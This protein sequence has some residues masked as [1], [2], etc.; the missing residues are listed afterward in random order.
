[1]A[2]VVIPEIKHEY[3]RQVDTETTKN[4]WFDECIADNKEAAW[5][6]IGT[7]E[8]DSQYQPS[9][10]KEPDYYMQYCSSDDYDYLK[11][12]RLIWGYGIGIIEQDVICS[13]STGKH[14]AEGKDACDTYATE[15]AAG[16]NTDWKRGIWI[17]FSGNRNVSPTRI[18]E[19]VLP[20]RIISLKDL[21]A[22][23]TLTYYTEIEGFNTENIFNI[24]GAFANKYIDATNSKTFDFS[25]ILS[26]KNT[27]QYVR[28]NNNTC[29]NFTN[30]N[31]ID[32]QHT[33]EYSTI[34][35]TPNG[36]ENVGGKYCYANSGITG[37]LK[38]INAKLYQ[39]QYKECNITNVDESNTF[40]AQQ[41]VDYAFSDNNLTNF[42]PNIN[43]SLTTSAVY[44][45]NNTSAN[46]ICSIDFN[47]QTQNIK[48]DNFIINKNY[49]LTLN[50]IAN[51]NTSLY[52]SEPAF[53]VK[54]HDVI[55][56][57]N[58]LKYSSNSNSGYLFYSIGGYIKII[59]SINTTKFLHIYINSESK[60]KFLTEDSNIILSND[61]TDV[62]DIGVYLI[63]HSTSSFNNLFFNVDDF[64][65]D[66][67][68]FDN[69]AYINISTGGYYASEAELTCNNKIITINTTKD[70]LY[71]GEFLPCNFTINL[72]DNTNVI[73]FGEENPN[74][75]NY[76]FSLNQ[77]PTLKLLND[78]NTNDVI[79]THFNRRD[80][81]NIGVKYFIYTK[82]NIKTLKTGTASRNIDCWL[83]IDYAN[84]I[85]LNS[86]NDDINFAIINK[87]C[88][89]IKLC[90]FD[91]YTTIY[92]INENINYTIISDMLRNGYKYARI[93][94]HRGIVTKSNNKIF[95]AKHIAL[96]NYINSDGEKIEY[97]TDVN[98]LD[99]VPYEYLIK[100]ISN[101]R[102]YIRNNY[103]YF[104]SVNGNKLVKSINCANQSLELMSL[105]NSSFKI[106]ETINIIDST[107]NC[108]F[109]GNTVDSYGFNNLII[110]WNDQTIITPIKLF[111]FETDIQH[112]L[113]NEITIE[114]LDEHEII[115]NGSNVISVCKIYIDSTCVNLTSIIINAHYNFNIYL[116]SY[117][118]NNLTTLLFNIDA[119]FTIK[120]DLDLSNFSN[121]SQ[122]SINSIINPSNYLNSATL[123][124][125][126]IPF[127][128]IT[129][130]QKQALVAAGVTLVE[131]IP[132]ETTE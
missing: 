86:N 24:D 3:I 27:F 15:N 112:I 108:T 22:A 31:D 88:N 130:E 79:I 92:T 125:N 25:N 59:G 117:F 8:L 131:Y 17:K 54:E 29:F 2:E 126:T 98:Q 10:V 37:E 105:I 44:F 67:I 46:L 93:T 43:W 77:Y 73:L 6:G 104:D 95:G 49:D 107:F 1:M 81:Y 33:F 51:N 50:I 87:N 91:V 5:A 119:G 74:S 13:L 129:E 82:S 26:A 36:F 39:H 70:N 121:L 45:L 63:C 71:I 101:A 16:E 48:I 123:T 103:I 69:C 111:A 114:V 21:C 116:D 41:N 75:S 109:N 18:G 132:T 106:D 102:H 110:N 53:N 20:E 19:V 96:P 84:Q 30:V 66:K 23:L 55:Y 122:E 97:I 32:Y 128:Y 12:Y 28:F 7:G 42:S 56:I 68:N 57:T 9:P 99:D 35:K 62:P 85:I 115:K 83:T 78:N 4:D 94:F 124:I 61:V 113:N 38:N 60:N 58:V 34:I 14:L 40:I 120:T 72:K 52:S 64:N 127:Q 11:D 76:Y 65:Y 100:N 90:N 80:P 47:T 118:Y 89:N